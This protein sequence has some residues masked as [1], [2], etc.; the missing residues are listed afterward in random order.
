MKWLN[1]ILLAVTIS[2]SIYFFTQHGKSGNIFYGDALGYYSYLPAT[3]I[4]D[5]LTH[6]DSSCASKPMPPFFQDYIITSNAGNAKT[7]DGKTLVQYTIGIAL[8]ECPSFLI[9]HGYA[10][11]FSYKIDGFSKPYE[12]ALRIC[13]W[14][15]CLIGL[16]LI[17]FSLRNFFD[18]QISIFV[19]LLSFIGTN[20]LYFTL[21]QNGM[22]HIPIFFCYA[23]LI[24]ITIKLHQ[25]PKSSYFIIAAALC[26]YIT[27]CRPSDIICI[28][29]PLFYNVY[30]KQSFY[31]KLNFIKENRTKLLVAILFFFLPILPQLLYW[32]IMT[33]NF[34]WYSYGSQTFDFLHPHLIEGWLYPGNG[35][36]QYTP[37]MLFA[38]IG[39]LF[40]KRA[41][42]FLYLMPFLFLL[43]SYII[44]SWFC[45]QY[46]NGFGSRPMLHLYPLLAFP[47]AAF[48]QFISEKKFAFKLS[49]SLVM[50]LCVFV[51]LS[52]SIK[53]AK[54]ELWSE[55]SSFKF[56]VMT[57]FKP[58][59]NYNDLV[60]LDVQKVQ[61]DS[62]SF[63]KIIL[64]KE[65]NF[66]KPD[67]IFNNGIVNDSVSKNKFY[68]QIGEEFS[69]TLV[70]EI[71]D[72]QKFAGAKYLKVSG[73]FNVQSSPWY[74]YWLSSLDMRISR[75]DNQVYYRSCKIDNK[76][77]VSKRENNYEGL[78]IFG[79]NN[80]QWDEVHFYIPLPL[81]KKLMN[82][83]VIKVWVSN[84]KKGEIWMDDIR[85]DLCY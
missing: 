10:K 66:E 51:N 26:G 46:I 60:L 48:I 58:K 20:L 8:A 13:N 38:V 62:N 45:Y 83:D 76:I 64:M 42:P 23:W 3:F 55:F 7:P 33:G 21:Y 5:N 72:E 61:P 59:I 19:S 68:K 12:M 35:W 75:D 6:M 11:I 57:L 4:Y 71:Y 85:I 73:R 80:K 15:Y 31:Q 49:V 18:K 65:N 78:K 53:Q 69:P 50:A 27:L 44:Y 81:R 24:F 30:N 43:Y 1:R 84:C 29:I 28:F 39:F 41:K 22:S 36:L 56:N 52:F 34:Y 70:S 17:Y 67:S 32:K 14:L 54:N 79:A 2:F 82:G 47:L 9:G 63:S 16:L 25:K 77:G 74:Y 37:I 40:L